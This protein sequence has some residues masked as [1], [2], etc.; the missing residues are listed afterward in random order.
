MH[1]NSTIKWLKIA[2]GIVIGF[3]IL[4]WVSIHP[5][6]SGLLAFLIDFA[7]WPIDGQQTLSALELRFILAVSGGI[8]IGWGILLW[9][10]STRLYPQDPQ[11]ARVM[12]LTSMGT[13]FVIDGIGSV[14]V[15]APLN[16][17]LNIPFLLIF[18]IPLWNIEQTLEEVG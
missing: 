2:S 10:I 7:L 4:V 9:M 11:L 1:H 3:G 8:V 12:I 5:A 15:G 14:M 13:W 17:L 6:L 16:V 18:L